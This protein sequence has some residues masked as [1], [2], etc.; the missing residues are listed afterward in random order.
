MKMDTLQLYIITLTKDIVFMDGTNI[1]VLK[2]LASNLLKSGMISWFEN[3]MMYMAPFQCY[4]ISDYCDPRHD[5]YCLYTIPKMMYIA[6]EH[7]CCLWCR[8]NTIT[9]QGKYISEIIIYVD[10]V[11]HST[12]FHRWPHLRLY[13]IHHDWYCYFSLMHQQMQFFFLISFK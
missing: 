8:I 7:I 12:L 5:S 11:S 9:I 10:L 3:Q 4:R 2:C 1:Y 13:C 6:E